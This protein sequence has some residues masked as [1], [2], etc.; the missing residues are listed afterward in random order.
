MVAESDTVESIELAA[1]DGQPLPAALAGQYLTLRITGAAEPPPV[2]TYSLSSAPG[3][4][5]YRISVKCEG[6]ASG[7]LHATLRPGA[8]LDVAAP[9]GQFVLDD[10]DGPVVLLSAG[11]GVTPLMAMLHRLAG[12]GS[13][14]EVWW[15]HAARRPSEHAL[16]AEAHDLLA[17]LPHAHEHVFYSAATADEVA[18]AGALPGRVSAERLRNLGIPTDAVAYVCGPAAFMTAM[19]DALSALGV[20]DD[21]IHIETFGTLGAV[22]PGLATA[23]RPA[24]HRPQGEPGS[25]PM[26][27]FARSGLSVPFDPAGHSILELAEACDVPTRWSCRTGVCHTCATALLDGRVSYSPEPLEPPAAGEVL[28]CCA[29]PDVDVVLDL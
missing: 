14:R 2:R 5:T 8:L 24:P 18:A 19:H 26:V 29:A 25:G 22:N 7:Y 27:T 9:R 17:S 12:E 21:R 10:E 4:A 20:S 23:V 13:E 15:V 3:A 6:L 16:A 1:D 28:V 11:V